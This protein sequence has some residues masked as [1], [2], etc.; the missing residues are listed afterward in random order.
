MKVSKETFD[1][2]IITFMTE[3]VLP[4]VSGDFQRGLI[5]GVTALGLPTIH[6]FGTMIGISGAE[7]VDVDKL[8]VFFK[9]MF[10]T[11]PTIRVPGVGTFERG[12]AETLLT[13]YLT[14]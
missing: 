8:K 12:D 11:Q 14:S 3:Q 1:K 9:G 4:K 2:A 7:G 10:D 13:Q 5:G 6:N